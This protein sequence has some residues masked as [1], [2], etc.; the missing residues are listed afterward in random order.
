MYFQI[1]YIT[2]DFE[3]GD[4][5]I[6][7]SDP[8]R[9]INIL[10]K[11]RTSE[12]IPPPPSLETGDGIV[13]ITCEKEMTETVHSEAVSSG[14][15]SIKKEGVKEVLDEMMGLNL[16]VLR[17]VRWRTNSRGR[18]NPIR[19]A[20]SG[21]FRWSADGVEWKP[22]ADSMSLRMTLGPQSPK[23]TPE[24]AEFVIAEACG[25]LDE[26]LA[27]EMLREASANSSEYARSSLVLA[28]AAAEVGFKQF[29]SKTF[30]DNGW[31]QS[32]RSQS[33]PLLQM[34]TEFPW[35]KVNLRIN[36]KVPTIPKSILAGIKDG[37]RVRNLVV[38]AGIAKLESE[39]V[40]S[41]L[42]AV[43]ELLYF[44]DALCICQSWPYDYIG[45]E[46]R[47]EFV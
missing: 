30:S 7:V 4:A 27:H 44:L 46:A 37:I 26:P 36:G 17:L 43:R 2:R 3:F 24:I 5:K 9:K 45:P 38:H 8:A 21:G 13:T 40:D 11:K 1:R 41:V 20:L 19:N 42:T 32:K 18:P 29:A 22:V 34:I 10:L 23:W 15:L 6:S 12:E 16:R 47:K 33:K 39:T 31:F 35:S 25:K 14:Q 28:I